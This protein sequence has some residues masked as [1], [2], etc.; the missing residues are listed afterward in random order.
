MITKENVGEIPDMYTNSM[1]FI[2]IESGEFFTD[3]M[4]TLF[5]EGGVYRKSGR[6][7]VIIYR[8]VGDYLFKY[9]ET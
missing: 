2:D 1:I 5:F 9:D 7:G 8:W 4:K 3:L 6:F